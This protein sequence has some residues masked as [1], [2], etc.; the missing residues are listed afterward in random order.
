MRKGSRFIS[1]GILQ[2][3]LFV[4]AVSAQAGG[5]G[6]GTSLADSLSVSQRGV[7]VNSPDNRFTIQNEPFELRFA[8]MDADSGAFIYVSR[9]PKTLPALPLASD[10]SEFFCVGH[11]V[12]RDRSEK[13]A[14]L[15]FDSERKNNYV[16]FEGIVGADGVA[17]V[18][19]GGFAETT[20][21]A[22]SP[23]ELYCAAYVDRNGDRLIDPSE[24]VLFSLVIEGQGS[25]FGK[26]VYV[27][28]MGYWVPSFVFSPTD[29]SVYKITSVDGYERF[30]R[31]VTSMTSN[32]KFFFEE[33]GGAAL[34]DE[35]FY[36][37]HSPVTTETFLNQPYKYAGGSELVF[38]VVPSTR[39]LNCEYIAARNYRVKRSQ[40]VLRICVLENGRMIYPTVYEY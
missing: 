18:R 14:T 30:K 32:Y 23:R 34:D 31:E 12:A 5:A 38:E 4:S 3:A 25:L 24:V 17:R 36:I 11:T 1:C 26:K 13:D 22:A 29:Y 35:C 37:V 2:A 21:L 6:T 7:A 27:S 16:G 33:K 8:D 9:D 28:T 40:D 20:N 15:Y 19:V 39:K 10:E